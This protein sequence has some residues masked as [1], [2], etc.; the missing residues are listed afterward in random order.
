MFIVMIYYYMHS[1]YWLWI[2]S[3]MY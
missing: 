2:V 3:I 1:C